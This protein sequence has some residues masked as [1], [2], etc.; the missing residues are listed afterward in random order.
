MTAPPPI[1]QAYCDTKVPEPSCNFQRWSQYK[2]NQYDSTW[3][4]T[5]LKQSVYLSSESKLNIDVDFILGKYFKGC[6]HSLL[7]T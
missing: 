1:R 4:V 7:M 2:Q 6:L 5:D 3:K